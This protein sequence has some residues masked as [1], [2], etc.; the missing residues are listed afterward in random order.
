[1]SDPSN[2][3]AAPRAGG[4]SRPEGGSSQIDSPVVWEAMRQ[5]G[6]WVTFLAVLG[7]LASGL[8]VVATLAMLVAAVATGGIA[9]VAV[10]LVYGAGAAL[11]LAASYYLFVYG[12]RIREF[13][14]ERQT[15]LLEAALV[16]QKSFWKLLGI[17]TAVYLA[18]V[19]LAIPAFIFIGVAAQRVR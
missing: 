2:P 13:V 3:F 6:P 19:V 5:T 17:V 14:R 7:F 1:M 8:M 9:Q 12:Q 11:Y 18:L 4:F 16:A 15:L 10:A